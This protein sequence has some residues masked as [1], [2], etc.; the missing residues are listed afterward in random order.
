MKKR[1]ALTSIL[2]FALF[3]LTYTGLDYF[4]LFKT[5]QIGEAIDSLNGVKVYYNGKVGNVHGRNM[6]DG[7]NVGLKYQCVEFVKR[8]Y[9]EHL[10]HKMPDSYGHALSFFDL[11]IEDGKLN[12]K[13]NLLQFSH[14]SSSKPMV[15]DLMVMDKT[16]FN[17]YGHVVIVSKVTDSYIEIIQQNPG[18]SVSSRQVY[19]LGQNEEGK[20]EIQ[21]KRILGWLRKVAD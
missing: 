7:Y 6:Q 5:Y 2:L 1:I 9:Y 8:Y 11:D 4:Q 10:Q 19:K 21:H 17:S 15:S 14:P 20:W 3:F 16:R 18:I 12:S 13:R